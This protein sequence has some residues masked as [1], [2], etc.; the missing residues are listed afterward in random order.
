MKVVKA[1]G[2]ETINKIISNK[3]KDETKLEINVW[4]R[5]DNSKKIAPEK[6]NREL[7]KDITY[8]IMLHQNN[9][10]GR[11]L[12]I[13]NGWRR[14][15]LFTILAQGQYSWYTSYFILKMAMKPMHMNKAKKREMAR[16]AWGVWQCVGFCSFICYQICIFLWKNGKTLIVV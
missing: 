12:K 14:S 16:K 4:I 10:K 15:E 8:R 7:W 11:N 13:D 3:M 1:C 9:Q 2:A 6:T 5:K